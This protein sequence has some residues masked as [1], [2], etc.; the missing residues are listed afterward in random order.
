V[1][2]V[3]RATRPGQVILRGTLA[4][5]ADR[6]EGADLRQA[7]VILVGEALQDAAREDLVESHL[8][9]VRERNRSE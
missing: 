8:Y 4:D 5:I 3:A 6:V 1:A 9:G 7:A 2:V